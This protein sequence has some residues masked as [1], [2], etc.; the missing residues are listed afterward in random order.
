MIDV[1]TEH[2]IPL[3]QL[4]KRLPCRRLGRPVHAGTIHRWR[5][6]GLRNVRLECLRVGGIWCTT[7]A[8]VQRFCERLSGH[9][10]PDRKS[11]QA[12]KE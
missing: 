3:S 10:R 12:P 4:A 6:P 11:P 8:A 2:L 7:F 9:D 1:R 5:H